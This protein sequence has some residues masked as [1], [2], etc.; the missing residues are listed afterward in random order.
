MDRLQANL[1]SP[2]APY[3]VT[4]YDINWHI[5]EYPLEVVT[6]ANS[7]LIIA[8]NNFATYATCLNLPL[9]L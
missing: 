7:V 6:L 2:H 5:Q 3:L 4:H 1:N 8:H 9:P